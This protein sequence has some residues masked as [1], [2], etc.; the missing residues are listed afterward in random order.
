VG[1]FPFRKFL[2]NLFLGKLVSRIM[3]GHST[4]RSYLSRFI[5]VEEAMCV[6]ERFCPTAL[7][8]LNVQLVT[9]VWDLYA[10][11]C[12]KNIL[13]NIIWDLGARFLFECPEHTQFY[14]IMIVCERMKESIK[15][16]FILICHKTFLFGQIL[17]Q[18]WII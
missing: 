7:T 14:P 8:V 5:I 13:V 15:F 1:H 4:A 6:T 18:F 17:L 12:S 10:L 2:L 16:I 3:S 11:S 9:P